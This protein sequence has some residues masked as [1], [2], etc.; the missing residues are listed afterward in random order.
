MAKLALWC[1]GV[2]VV[3]AML[4]S[5]PVESQCTAKYCYND[6]ETDVMKMLVNI[7]QGIV[8]LKEELSSNK[9]CTSEKEEIASKKEKISSLKEKLNECCKCCLLF[10]I[11]R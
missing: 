6:D 11:I 1:L 4:H 7:Q 2:V 9:E 10:C 5:L 3:A 8:S